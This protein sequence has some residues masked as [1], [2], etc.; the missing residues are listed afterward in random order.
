MLPK[1]LWLLPLVFP[2]LAFPQGDSLPRHDLPPKETLH[3][4]VEWRLITAGK[5]RLEWSALPEP[6]S[7]WQAGLHLRSV[8]IVSGLY[9]VDDAYTAILNGNLC[10]QSAHSVTREGSRHRE[11]KIAF[12]SETRKA[13][14]H[15]R[16]RVKNTT[17]A[18]HEID[19]PP[20]VHDVVGGLYFLRTLSIEPGKSVELPISDG[21]KSVMAKVEAQQREN[22]KTP[23]GTFKTVRYQVFLFNNVLYRRS[24]RLYVWLTEDRRRLP[25]QIRV[26]MQFTIGTITLQLE[27]IE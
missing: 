6:R 21:K 7:G 22:I 17:V 10:T 18:T 14:Y 1:P 26:R 12:N 4:N 25:V 24:A 2:T 20:C 3:Y 9:K 15:E 11:T 27:K 5:A 16:D 13:S 19:I 23:A 8:G